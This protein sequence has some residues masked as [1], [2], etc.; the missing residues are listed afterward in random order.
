D[1][2]ECAVHRMAPICE[3]CDCKVLGHGTEVDGHFYCC[4]HCARVASGS[5]RVADRVG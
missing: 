3:H 2:F 1:S 5:D 4:A